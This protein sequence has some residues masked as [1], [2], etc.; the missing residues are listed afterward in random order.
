MTKIVKLGIRREA[1]CVYFL[2]G[3]DV[4]RAPSEDG[5][6]FDVDE[7]VLV[8]RASFEREPGYLYFLDPDGDI[9]REKEPRRRR[10]RTSGGEEETATASAIA[11][12]VGTDHDG[13]EESEPA[14]EQVQ[15][16]L[17]DTAVFNYPDVKTRLNTLQGYFFPRLERLLD[18]IVDGIRAVYDLDPFEDMT[19]TYRPAHR[20]DA[21]V[22]RDFG[23]VYIG[24]TAKRSKEGLVVRHENGKPYMF[25]P[26]SLLV[27]ILPA[28][29]LQVSLR[30][31]LYKADEDFRRLV[32]A[33]VEQH[34][35]VLGPV[36]ESAHI[37]T[38]D[39]SW[40][41]TTGVTTWTP[42]RASL[43][44][45]YH[46]V[47]PVAPFPLA[48]DHWLGLVVEQFIVLYPVLDT[49]TRLAR[50]K[51][52]RLIDLVERYKAA[53]EASVVESSEGAPEDSHEA[54]DK[55][56]E[57]AAAGGD[58][59]EE[60]WPAQIEASLSGYT[61]VRPGKWYAVLARDKWT[62]CSC[63]RS[64]RAHG[65]LLEVDH[66]VPRSKGGTDDLDNLQTLCKKCN[67]GK[68]NKDDTRLRA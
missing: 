58:V 16:E 54:G 53:V 42:L 37:S 9:S 33:S 27:S 48:E 17:R 57:E 8:R 35:D 32:Q 68:S 21:K 63:G 26:S 7:G 11:Q 20:T 31:Y 22:V 30:P 43:A 46:W 28:G 40:A 47:G 50:G 39:G 4:W 25:G 10:T 52:E 45:G 19:V 56:E 18:L 64:T 38:S 36:M 51:P 29:A 23:E 65:V 49:I 1:G 13:P 61:F 66:I 12:D 55:E 67:L 15:F 60:D 3:T 14:Q 24:L 59:G 5:E 62:C 34:W 44:D 2:K 41:G 6:H